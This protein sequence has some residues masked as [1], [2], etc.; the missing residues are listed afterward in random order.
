MTLAHR[1]V[2]DPRAGWASIHDRADLAAVVL[3]CHSAA[4]RSFQGG[5]RSERGRSGRS[6]S[7]GGRDPS[8]AG[9]RLGLVW[10]ACR[11]RGGCSSGFSTGTSRSSGASSPNSRSRKRFRFSSRGILNRARGSSCDPPGRHAG[12]RRSPGGRF[13]TYAAR[14]SSSDFHSRPRANHINTASGCRA[15]SCLSVGSS[16][17][18]VCGAEGR[19]LALENDRPVGVAWRHE[20]IY[21]RVVR[22]V[23][24]PWVAP[25]FARVVSQTALAA[26]PCDGAAASGPVG[27]PRAKLLGE[28]S[29]AP[30]VPAASASR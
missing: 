8:T 10:V 12:P 17:S 15:C 26:V 13:W 23:R 16:S 29:A 20:K 28:T 18:C 3:S 4:G 9:G 1:R 19:R 30:A 5:C 7:R 24:G 14:D 27:D 11:R 25:S 22:V 21:F 2:T 6:P